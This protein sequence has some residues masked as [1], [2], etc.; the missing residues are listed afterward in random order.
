MAQV[1]RLKWQRSLALALA[2]GPPA[3]AWHAPG[4]VQISPIGHASKSAPCR[5]VLH[6]MGFQYPLPG[7]CTI[8]KRGQRRRRHRETG[9]STR[10]RHRHPLRARTLPRLTDSRA[11]WAVRGLRFG[12][13]RIRRLSFLPFQISEHARGHVKSRRLCQMVRCDAAPSRQIPGLVCGDYYIR[14]APRHTS[15]SF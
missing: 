1:R 3:P 14:A 6:A 4:L 11:S 15:S 7:A 2:H 13:S 12:A 8:G 9:V 10:E 5:A